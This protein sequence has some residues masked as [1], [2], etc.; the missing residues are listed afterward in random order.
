MRRPVLVILFCLGAALGAGSC[1]S[2]AE[3][4]RKPYLSG[5]ALAEADDIPRALIE[6]SILVSDSPLP[7]FAAARAVL[8]RLAPP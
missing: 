1:Q 4:A 5:L 3:K 8:A 7:A 6:L 2:A